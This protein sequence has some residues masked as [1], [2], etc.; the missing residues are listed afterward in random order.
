MKYWK[1]FTSTPENPPISST[2]EYLYCD[3]QIPP[4]WEKPR[5]PDLDEGLAFGFAS[6]KSLLNFLIINFQIINLT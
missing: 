2:R 5:T 6:H 1:K 3:V 4:I